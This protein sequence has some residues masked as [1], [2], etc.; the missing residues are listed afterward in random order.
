MLASYAI[1]WKYR[2][3]VRRAKLGWTSGCV[4]QATSPVGRNNGV[5]AV[6]RSKPDGAEGDRG[7]GARGSNKAGRNA[8]PEMVS[9]NGIEPRKV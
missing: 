3:Y 8:K 2:L 9:V 4:V 1:E 6:C 5:K 7:A